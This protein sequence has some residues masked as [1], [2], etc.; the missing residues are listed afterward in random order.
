MELANRSLK[1]LFW[2]NLWIAFGASCTAYYFS[3]TYYIT[4]SAERFT[5]TLFVYFST[6]SV[7]TFHRIIKHA[8]FENCHTPRH[9]WLYNN[10]NALFGIGFFSLIC[11]FLLAINT[12]NT[13]SLFFLLLP[14]TIIMTL[15]PPLGEKFNG[16]R[17]RLVLKNLAVTLVWLG[18]LLIV[19]Y[20][21]YTAITTNEVLLQL[22]VAFALFVF[23]LTL[24]FDLR[25]K[26]HD[27]IKTLGTVLPR[28]VNK[29]VSIVCLIGAG[30]LFYR[31]KVDYI[32]VLP[33]VA[34]GVVILENKNWKEM[35]YDVLVDGLFI[36]FAGIMLF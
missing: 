36:L 2:G 3:S 28:N 34:I 12:L 11:A 19:P 15:Y 26:P 29:I 10:K 13:K 30:M 6:L 32:Y 9:I 21:N 20:F 7:Y 17:S 16:I 35:Y 18:L 5:F 31:I 4:T 14:M 22:M 27:L 23:A 33:F 24:P 8:S 1:W 25:D